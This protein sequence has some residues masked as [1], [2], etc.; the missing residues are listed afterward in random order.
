MPFCDQN[1]GFLEKKNNFSKLGKKCDRKEILLKQN[2]RA[3]KIPV[4]ARGLVL[5]SNS[6]TERIKI[7]LQM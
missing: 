5:S 2:W 7:K 3:E 1:L 6:Q 4:I